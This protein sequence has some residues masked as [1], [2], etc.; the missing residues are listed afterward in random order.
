MYIN[1]ITKLFMPIAVSLFENR[2]CKNRPLRSVEAPNNRTSVNGDG[3]IYNN[4]VINKQLRY[5]STAY[6]KE[7]QE[8]SLS[9]K[10]R[11]SIIKQAPKG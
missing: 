10:I 3:K 5:F 8:I 1:T 2:L 11:N 6:I 4:A 7:I 9:I